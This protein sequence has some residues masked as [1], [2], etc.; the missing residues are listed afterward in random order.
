VRFYIFLGVKPMPELTE[1]LGVIN[2]TVPERAPPLAPHLRAALENRYREP[3]R[4]LAALLGP[5]FLIWEA[6]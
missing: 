3:N 1:R 4:R 5:E 2:A 6:G